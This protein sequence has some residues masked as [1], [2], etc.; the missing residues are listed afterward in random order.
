MT[1]L[2]VVLERVATIDFSLAW[3]GGEDGFVTA[4]SF[5]LDGRWLAVRTKGVAWLWPLGAADAVATSLEARPCP[6][7][8]ADEE[9][10]EA[11]GFS[12]S[13]FMTLSEGIGPRL[14]FYPWE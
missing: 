13:G 6:V 11:L 9:Q 10:G 8:L 3:A 5:S 12:D 4:A 2:E 1:G 14:Y 7:V